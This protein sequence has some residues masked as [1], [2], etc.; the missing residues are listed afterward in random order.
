MKTLFRVVVRTTASLQPGD[1]HWESKVAYCGYDWLE[2]ARVFHVQA[3]RDYSGGY[4]GR[5]RRTLC[6][7]TEVPDEP[8]DPENARWVS[9]TEATDA[10]K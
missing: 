8:A 6:E 10:A 7:Q 5:C 3:P 9:V 1:G 2:A 4:G